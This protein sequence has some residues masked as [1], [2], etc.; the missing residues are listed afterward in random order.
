MLIS[1]SAA[2]QDGIKVIINTNLPVVA[3][4][5]QF[6]CSLQQIFQK[7]HRQGWA[8][9]ITPRNS[10]VFKQKRAFSLFP[11]YC[12]T[13]LLESDTGRNRANKQF[14]K[15]KERQDRFTGRFWKESDPKLHQLL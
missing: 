12:F 10:M 8:F 15:A 1:S 14:R 2:A 6:S 5:K 9:Y 11:F 7:A 4:R 3:N 13:A